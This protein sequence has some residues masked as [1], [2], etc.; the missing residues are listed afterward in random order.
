MLEFSSS[1]EKFDVWP[2][3]CSQNPVKKTFCTVINIL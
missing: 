3:G 1:H 2:E